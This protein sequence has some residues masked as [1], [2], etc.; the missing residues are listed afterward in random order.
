M[1]AKRWNNQNTCALQAGM[2]ICGR[3]FS[4]LGFSQT[5]KEGLATLEEGL[6]TLDK[7]LAVS[8]KARLTFTIGS[9]IHSPWY[10]PKEVENTST[11]KP[12][13]GCF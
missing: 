9:S 1:L 5:A 7:G 6:A 11:E 10:L 13:P 12:G 2:Q 3:G 4:S 8:Y